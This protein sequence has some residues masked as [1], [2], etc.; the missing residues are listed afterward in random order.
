VDQKVAQKAARLM[1]ALS[2]GDLVFRRLAK[3]GDGLATAWI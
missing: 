1:M 3:I 2:P